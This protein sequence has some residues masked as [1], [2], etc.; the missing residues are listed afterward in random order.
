MKNVGLVTITDCD[1]TSDYSYV[2]VYYTVLD[3]KDKKKAYEG[4]NASKKFLRGAIASAVSMR[5]IPD[6]IFIYDD[7]YEK[8]QRIDELLR[9]LNSKQ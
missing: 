1:L 2:R 8:G 5:R 7:S 6:P 9:E 4:L 3:P